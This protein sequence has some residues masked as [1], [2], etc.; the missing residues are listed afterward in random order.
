MYKFRNKEKNYGNKDTTMVTS[1]LEE[2][3][4][5]RSENNRKVQTS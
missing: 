4:R 1:I 5:K 3:Q 2:M